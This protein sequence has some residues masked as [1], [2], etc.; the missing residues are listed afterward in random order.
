MMSCYII[1]TWHKWSANAGDVMVT[2]FASYVDLVTSQ[3]A[4]G[5]CACMHGACA[6]SEM[7][8][9]KYLNGLTCMPADLN[10]RKLTATHFWVL[11]AQN[12]NENMPNVFLI[13]YLNDNMRYCN[14][15]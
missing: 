7:G 1:P 15:N 11:I 5:S 3:L 2:L 10:L 8:M 9:L 14:E 12:A 13:V 6:L 4:C